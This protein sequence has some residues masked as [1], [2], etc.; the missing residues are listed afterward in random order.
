MVI[1]GLMD[2]LKSLIK[3]LKNGEVVAKPFNQNNKYGFE[4][5][6]TIIIPPIYAEVFPFK[7]GLAKV[8]RRQRYGFVDY[9]GN[10][11]IPCIYDYSYDFNDS[12]CV[13]GKSGKGA[14][15][16]YKPGFCYVVNRDNE[17]VNRFDEDEIHG[18]YFDFNSFIESI[19]DDYEKYRK[20]LNLF[21][22]EKLKRLV[23]SY[24]NRDGERIESY[25]YDHI[26]HFSN[27]I[28]TVETNHRFGLVSRNNRKEILPC[29]Y[30]W[31]SQLNEGFA[32]TKRD[33][34][35]G[36]LDERGNIVLLNKYEYLDFAG[37]D[38]FLVRL[39]NL[40]GIININ[41]K[42]ILPIVYDKIERIHDEIREMLEKSLARRSKKKITDQKQT[43]VFW[44]VMYKGLYAVFTNEFRE[45]TDFIYHEVELRSEY[46][47]VRK[48]IHWGLLDHRLKVVL[49][50][51]F[52]GIEIRSLRIDVRK[53]NLWG[54]CD[55]NGKLIYDFRY[56][57]ILYDF[58]DWAKK[59]ERWGM[60]DR[61]G[62]PLTEFIYSPVMKRGRYSTGF[63]IDRVSLNDRTTDPLES[64]YCYRVKRH[65]KYGLIN[66]FGSIIADCIYDEL[67]V[68]NSKPT[69]IHYPDG[70]SKEILEL[71]KYRKGNYRG[72]IDKNGK[73]YWQD[74][75]RR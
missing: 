75:K 26:W 12:Y 38:L 69:T 20:E 36:V 30:D 31:I 11:V 64:S 41:E 4:V 44:S 5:D 49:N 3:K 16:D 58:A 66:E 32:I 10:E 27:S 59:D 2:K 33:G 40:M 9:F 42:I 67:R 24:V 35:F 60:I 55:L 28:N 48:G 19:G 47:K 71:A 1:K 56:Q 70:T 46:L 15:E 8:I 52:K 62:N 17:R 73:E 54:I 43:Q 25:K 57:A 65:R 37:R 6:G 45:S 22:N 39:N 21:Y 72:Y 14:Y 63:Y 50:L 51:E 29:E 61:H 23:W 74:W 18:L 13:V 7:D 53:K 68:F 34:L